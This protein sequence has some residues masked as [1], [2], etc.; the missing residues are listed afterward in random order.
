MAQCLS[1]LW[2]SRFSVPKF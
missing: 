2:M 1:N